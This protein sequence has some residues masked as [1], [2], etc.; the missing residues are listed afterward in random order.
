M[1][2]YHL[3]HRAVAGCAGYQ[4]VQVKL[5]D[6]A[7]R[8]T[9]TVMAERNDDKPM[10]F[11]DCSLISQ[12]ASALLE[13]EDPITGAYDLEVCSPGID[14]PLTK[15]KDF[16]RFSGNEAKV[17]TMIPIDGRRKF[18]GRIESVEGETIT[19]HMPEGDAKIEFRNIRSARLS[20]PNGGVWFDKRQK[21]KTG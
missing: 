19:L 4:L 7:R 12:T 16:V 11:D 3:G 8:K 2:G 13:V 9:L 20:P 5:A 21:K 15:L 18:R 10:G 1:R 6:S 17:E 14:R